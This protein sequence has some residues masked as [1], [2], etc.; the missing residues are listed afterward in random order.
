[1]ISE[2]RSTAPDRLWLSGSYGRETMAIH[3]TWR[4]RPGEVD[5]VLREVEAALEPFAARP[6]WGKVSHVTAGQVARVLPPA[7]RRERPVRTA[8]PGRPVQQP[9]P[10][11]TGRPRRPL[12]WGGQTGIH[13]RLVHRGP[14][15]AHAE[16]HPARRCRSRPFRHSR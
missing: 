15:T 4:N 13:W 3:F 12:T 14:V 16:F 7:R 8:R 2:I 6:H 11:T 9:P 1:M 5:A 10:G